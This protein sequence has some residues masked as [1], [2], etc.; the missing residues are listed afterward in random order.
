M[1]RQAQEPTTSAWDARMGHYLR[2]A[3]MFVSQKQYHD[4][5]FVRVDATLMAD[6]AKDEALTWLRLLI[7]AKRTEDLPALTVRLGSAVWAT[8]C[9]TD[10]LRVSSS[11]QLAGLSS[12]CSLL[13]SLAAN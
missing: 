3:S 11:Q 10:L 8:S 7:R 6:A 1:W 13:W 5:E 2:A 12:V 9:L 4:S